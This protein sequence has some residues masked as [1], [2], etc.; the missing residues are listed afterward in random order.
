MCG[1]YTACVV[2]AREDRTSGP[3][4]RLPDKRTTKLPRGRAAGHAVRSPALCDSPTWRSQLLGDPS[5]ST[6][7]LAGR[8]LETRTP[9]F[10]DSDSRFLL[11]GGPGRPTVRLIRLVDDPRLWVPCG[12]PPA[13]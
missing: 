2:H 1:A 13:A 3:W 4:P 7:V 6:A 9:Q 8:P 11:T 5:P 10:F 12:S